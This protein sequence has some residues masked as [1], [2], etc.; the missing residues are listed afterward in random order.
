MHLLNIEHVG[1][2]SA[3][4]IPLLHMKMLNTSSFILHIDKVMEALS[5]RKRKKTLSEAQLEVMAN[6]FHTSGLVST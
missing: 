1:T 5:N 3:R 2:T 6:L 4:L